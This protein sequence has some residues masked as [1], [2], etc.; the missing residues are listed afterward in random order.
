MEFTEQE[1]YLVYLTEKGAIERYGEITAEIRE[2]LEY[3]LNVIISKGVTEYFLVLEDIVKYCKA[4]DIALGPGRGSAGG[5]VVAYCLY[6]TKIDPLQFD[7]LF[8]RFL[9]SERNAMPDFN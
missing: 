1:Q 3:E 7:L 6:I 2:R 5:S 4:N 9:N 8:D